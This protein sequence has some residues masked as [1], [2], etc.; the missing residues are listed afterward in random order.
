MAV[1]T[2][3]CK[4]FV[5]FLNLDLDHRPPNNAALMIYC[6]KQWYLFENAPG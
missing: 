5:W 1:V 3:I 4:V 2:L 6:H